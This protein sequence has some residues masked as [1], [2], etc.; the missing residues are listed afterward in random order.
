MD[1]DW[2]SSI[3]LYGKL[4][5]ILIS[6]AP[7]LNKLER[8]LLSLSLKLIYSESQTKTEVCWLSKYNK[9][10]WHICHAVGKN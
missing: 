7:T 3:F 4:L 9:N 8:V 6:V 2:E 5:V 10:T 1:S